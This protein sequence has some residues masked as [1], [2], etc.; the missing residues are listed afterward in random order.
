MNKTKIKTDNLSFGLYLSKI[1]HNSLIEH[2]CANI[3]PDCII[4]VIL[5]NEHL[6]DDCITILYKKDLKFTTEMKQSMLRAELSIKEDEQ[7]YN[8]MSLLFSKKTII[9][10]ILEYTDESVRLEIIE[11]QQS[12]EKPKLNNIFYN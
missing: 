10:M 7:I 11:N 8:Y 9:N 5:E 3:F 6:M 2:A 4:D 12:W 1:D